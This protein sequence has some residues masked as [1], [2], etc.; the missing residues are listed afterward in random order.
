MVRQ[1]ILTDPVNRVL[2]LLTRP[3]VIGILA[4]FFFN[5]VDTWFISLLG[6]HSLAAVGFTLPVTLLVQNLAIGLGI[7]VSALMAR[8]VGQND[9]TAAQQTASAGLLLSFILGVLIAVGGWL[10]HDAIFRLLGAQPE[11]TG[12]IRTFMQ[13]WWPGAVVLLMMMLQTSAMRATG[14]TRLPS[15]LMLIGALLN[16]ALDPLLIFG[17]GPVPAMGVAGASLATT[18]CWLLILLVVVFNQLRSGYLSFQGLVWQAWLALCRRLLTLGIPAM[19]TNMLV[20]V[21]GAVLLILVAPLGP[22]A[23]AG[24]GVGMRIEPFALVVIL[25]LT[26]TLPVFVAQNHAAG[27]IS[28]VWQ[29]L[30]SSFRFIVLWQGIL[31]VLF[32]LTAPWLA[33]IFSADDTVQQRIVDYLWYMPVGYLGVGIVLCINAALN[34]LQRT[35]TSMVINAVRLF[36]FYVPAAWLGALL[37]G[38]SGL[39]IGAA[40]GNL[41]VGG[42]L[43]WQVRRVIRLHTHPA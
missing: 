22:E 15:L 39:L 16:A 10:S 37:A 3:M 18:L 40:L 20:P 38:Y 28:R 43:W 11:L 9:V 33:Q 35:R 19:I 21:A 6:T 30:F 13:F 12:E 31:C 8:A 24:F 7:A 32:W 42:L 25:A 14:N 41:L 1:M 26:S 29:A 34:S 27:H 2:F 5:L 17:W 36:G 23:V 4:I